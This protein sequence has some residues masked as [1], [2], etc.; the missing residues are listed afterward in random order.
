MATQA[1]SPRR[2]L[3]AD[4]K[5]QRDD[6]YRVEPKQFGEIL[7]GLTQIFSSLVLLNS[8]LGQAGK[9]AYLVWPHPQRPGEFLAF[10]RKHLRSANA[11]FARSILVLKNYLRVSRKK[12][13]DPVL[14]E[15]FSG[16]YTPVYAAE[17][18]RHFF[19]A[20]PQ[21]FGPLNPLQWVTTHQPGAAWNLPQGAGLMENLGMVQQGYLLR[22]TTTMLFYIYAHAMDLQN[23]A[24]AQLARSDNVMN[25][26]FGGAIAAAFYSYPDPSGRTKKTK[27]GD[28][29]PVIL[30]T[31][32]AQALA[33]GL[34]AAPLNTYD[35]IRVTHPDFNP[36]QFNTYY[37]QNIAAANYYSR[38]ALLADPDL[39]VAGEALQQ[40]NV[41]Q[42]M[43]NEHNIVKQVSAEWHQHL[44]PGRKVARDQRKR[45]ADAAKRAGR[46]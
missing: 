20:A 39:A 6:Q 26:A 7:R 5:R 3:T 8:A 44:E 31:T 1:A 15:N 41:R 19:T 34:I 38:A 28:Q 9:G 24:N 25:E 10:N 37:Y 45:D 4:E 40:D 35:V 30:K 16:T 23:A 12:T 46:R 29:V 27:S 32:M 22:N 33:Q 2:T 14:P 21:N 11:K 43:L 36:A 17:A 18:L 42:A 13:R